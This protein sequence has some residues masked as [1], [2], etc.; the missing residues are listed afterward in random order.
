MFKLTNDQQ[1]ALAVFEQFILDP[2]EKYMVIHGDSG[3]GKSTLIKHMMHHIKS[4]EKMYELLLQEDTLK[5]TIALTATTNKAAQVIS[6]MLE[7]DVMTI[8]SFLQ[9][10][11]VNNFSTGEKKL[12]K[13]N[14]YGIVHECL[15]I[16]DEASFISDEL[17]EFIE[18][19]TI[20]CKI[21]FIGD[22]YQL[23]PIKQKVPVMQTLSCKYQANLTEIMRNKGPISDLGAQFKESVK[24]NTFYPITCV[25]PSII[26]V[27]GLEFKQAIKEAYLS[28]QYTP[29]TS[30]ILAWTNTRVLEYNA[31]IRRIK[32]YAAEFTLGERVITNKPIFA[33]FNKYIADSQITLTY[34]GDEFYEN[35]VP[36]KSIQLNGNDKISYLLP[37]DLQAYKL[38]LKRLAKLKEWPIYFKLRDTWL[39]LRAVYASTIHK[40]QGSEYDTIFLD[41]FDLSKCHIPSDVARMLYVGATRAKKQLVLYG[42]LATKYGG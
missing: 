25:S 37:T 6:D 8:H 11:I 10:K 34:I 40:S 26:H 13:K 2:V 19:S 24:T 16:V 1:N 14:T 28:P 20:D 30:K 18:S 31:H 3:T 15:I 5:W 23:A 12:V 42:Q 39:D 9:L 21:I 35:D 22:Q 41:L 36:V 29:E 32:G 7:Q 4:T 38:A 17:F 27:D 33:K